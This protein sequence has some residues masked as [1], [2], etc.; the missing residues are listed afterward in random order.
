MR[1]QTNVQAE[2]LSNFWVTGNTHPEALRKLVAK[3][4]PELD[5]HIPPHGDL[6]PAALAQ[7]LSDKCGMSADEAMDQ[8]M[9]FERLNS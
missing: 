6:D 8:I 1:M 2:L 7:L 3:E 9:A 4:W 5:G